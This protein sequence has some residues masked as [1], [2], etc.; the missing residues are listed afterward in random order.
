M[1]P[2]P[3][4]PPVV[5]SDYVSFR[6]A[7]LH[8]LTLV[9]GP[10]H[11]YVKEVDRECSGNTRSRILG[12][13]AVVETTRRDLRLGLLGPGRNSRTNP[14][15][16]SLESF[17]P[18]VVAAARDLYR[19]GHYRQAVLDAFI[20]MV[21]RVKDV[22]GRNDP[23]DGKPLMHWVHGAFLGCRCSS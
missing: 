13:V 16:G 6:V 15:P 1:G 9:C 3:P 18:I 17:H 10:E 7:A 5:S 20:A 11:T 21:S 12:G 14:S 22:S 8:T 4:N 2:W 23:L 19:D